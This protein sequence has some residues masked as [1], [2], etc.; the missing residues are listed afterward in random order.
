[1]DDP[2][3]GLL[4]LSQTTPAAEPEKKVR[5]QKEALREM[6]REMTVAGRLYDFLWRIMA[7]AIMRVGI[8]FT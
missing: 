6:R 8:T 1:M 2:G 7:L 5:L 4:P 3:G